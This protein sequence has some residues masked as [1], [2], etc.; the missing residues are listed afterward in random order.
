MS[1]KPK[2]NKALK[3]KQLVRE[4][5]LSPKIAAGLTQGVPKREALEMHPVSTAPSGVELVRHMR[6][7]DKRLARDGRPNYA[8]F[9]ASED[10]DAVWYDEPTG[11]VQKNVVKTYTPEGMRL[12][13]EGRQCLRCDEPHPEPFPLAC[14]LCGYSMRER[15]IMDIAMEFEGLRHLGPNKPISEYLDEQDLRVEKKKFL[16]KKIEGGSGRIPKEWL[17]DAHLFPDGVPAELL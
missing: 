14:D 10:A 13:R 6:D 8:P 12:L 16:K 15:Q 17:R 3:K 5:D 9:V 11:R 2:R 7:A 1:R 4:D